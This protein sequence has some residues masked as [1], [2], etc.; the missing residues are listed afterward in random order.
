[1]NF[2]LSSTL[3]GIPLCNLLLGRATFPTTLK[4]FD[5]LFEKL[6]LTLTVIVQQ[7]RLI[8]EILLARGAGS[9]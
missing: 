1:M 7:K 9:L 4:L 6:C 8:C 2:S 3:L 5:P